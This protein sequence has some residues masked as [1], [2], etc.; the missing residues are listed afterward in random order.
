MQIRHILVPVDFSTCSLQVAG[1]AGELARQTGA[2]LTLLHVAEI[3]EGLSAG[4]KVRHEGREYTA[5]E[6]AEHGATPRME[7]YVSAA[8]GHGVEPAVVV[9]SG[10][11]APTI[12]REAEQLGA[13]LILMGTH[14][15]KGLARA[16]LGSVAE[17]VARHANV[18]VML[19][20]RSPRPECNQTS[21]DWCHE[22]AASREELELED[23][24]AG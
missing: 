13:D 11:V 7:R 17:E 16:V 22:R 20:R 19:V 24:R 15:R 23:E 9:H 3:P 1:G 21:C 14:G 2:R 10:P 4:A 5:T 6:W 12:A 18:P 8:R